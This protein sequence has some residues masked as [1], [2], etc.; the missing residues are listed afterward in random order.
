MKAEDII[1][2]S[3]NEVYINT[4]MKL[5]FLESELKKLRKKEITTFIY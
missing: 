5:D 2:N 3:H 1:K 4:D